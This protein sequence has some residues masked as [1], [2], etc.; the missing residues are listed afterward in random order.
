[1]PTMTNQQTE[2][3]RAEDGSSLIT[4]LMRDVPEI[5]A[6]NRRLLELYFNQM[7]ERGFRRGLDEGKAIFL[8]AIEDTRK[9][10]P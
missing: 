6:T 7:W 4:D 9:L 3:K 8:G 2:A 5:P 1:M 10:F